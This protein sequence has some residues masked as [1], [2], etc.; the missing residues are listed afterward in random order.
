MRGLEA[1]PRNR[2][3]DT[4]ANDPEN[5]ECQ[6]SNNNFYLRG[7]FSVFFSLILIPLM[8]TLFGIAWSIRILNFLTISFTLDN[9]FTKKY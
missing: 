8:N 2:Q 6:N 1:V 7:W 3:D 5:G 9:K 4:R